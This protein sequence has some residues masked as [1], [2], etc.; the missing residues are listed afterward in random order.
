MDGTNVVRSSLAL[1][2]ATM[3]LRRTSVKL[4]SKP[5]RTAS[6]VSVSRVAVGPSTAG[7]IV[8]AITPS[9]ATSGAQP[10]VRARGAFVDI[11]SSDR[12][13]RVNRH[14]AWRPGEVTSA[15]DSGHYQ[16]DWLT[17]FDRRTKC[18]LK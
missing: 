12:E 2:A 16:Q 6:N 4:R 8:Q 11:L 10:K 14:A 13:R 7:D 17:G 18:C 15:P 9:A 5:A 3:G 1:A